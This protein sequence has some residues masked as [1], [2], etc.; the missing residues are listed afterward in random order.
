M[1]NFFYKKNIF[2]TGGTGSFG[3]KFTKI[4]LD[5]FKLN[6]IVIFSRD[7]L[8]QFEMNEEFK[9]KKI[10]YLLGDIRDFDRVK[11]ALKDMDFVVH[12]AAL[13]QVPKA[14]YNPVEYI[15]T[16]IL[17]SENIIRAAIENNVKRVI[18]LSTDKACS[19][20]NLYGATKLVAD[21]LFSTANNITGK[22]NIIFS[23]VRY[24]NV[25]NSRGSVIP[26]F[27]SLLLEKKILPVTD[28]QVS[29]FFLSLD[30]GV[31]FVINCL[32][33]MKGGEIFIPKIPSFK[34]LDL[35]EILS[36]KNKVDFT[37]LRPGEKLHE[38]LISKDDTN[39]IEFKKFYIIPP[40]INFNKQR[41]YFSYKNLKGKIKNSFEYASN[42]NSQFLNKIRLKNLLNKLKIKI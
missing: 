9:S 32:Y 15:K 41:N 7:E 42:L 17:G 25:I 39:V 34:I 20:I 30:E 14:E 31:N 4:A 29:R 5:R 18:S 22:Q 21:K 19:P 6:K 3:K 2:I 13:K 11:Y 12:A 37:G 28:P 23:S 33:L 1:K 26:Y 10:R 35:A 38:V 27:K 36:K 8:K 24:G 40:T 16:N